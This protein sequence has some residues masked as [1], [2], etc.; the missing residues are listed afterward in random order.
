MRRE[1]RYIAFAD[2][3][4][5][6]ISFEFFSIYRANSKDNMDDAYKHYK[7][8]HGHGVHIVKTWREEIC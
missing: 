5:D 8:L 3:G 2:T 6:Y 4:R 1:K 7:K